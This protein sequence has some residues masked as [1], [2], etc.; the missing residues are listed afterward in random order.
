MG[1]G[2]PSTAARLARALLSHSLMIKRY[3]KWYMMCLLSSSKWPP[4]L[5]PTRL[6]SLLS[7]LQ[8]HLLSVSPS[9]IFR[10]LLTET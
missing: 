1:G 4:N 7:N 5:L 2:S 10:N 9:R 3:C 6:S 8:Y